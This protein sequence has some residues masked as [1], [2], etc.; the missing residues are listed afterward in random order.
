MAI[1]NDKKINKHYLFLIIMI[2]LFLVSI[3]LIIFDY[4]IS[5]LIPISMAENP[6]SVFFDEFGFGITFVPIYFMLLI[7]ILT[8]SSGLIKTKKNKRLIYII[9]QIVFILVNLLFYYYNDSF[10]YIKGNKYLLTKLLSSMISIIIFFSTYLGINIYIF[11][12]KLHKDLYWLTNISSKT[13]YAFFVIFFSQI[14]LQLIK[15]I[16]GRNRPDDVLF[17][18][19][20]FYYAFEPNFNK[21]R[22]SSFVSGHVLSAG[23]LFIFLFFLYIPNKKTKMIKIILIVVFSIISLLVGISRITMLKHFATDVYFSGVLLFVFFYYSK[24][25][26]HWFRKKMRPRNV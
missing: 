4:K 9:F 18:N 7:F 22:G 26:V 21:T 23:L 12:K 15:V 19:Q 8:I 2:T 20:T 1:K 10:A 5:Q 24:D 6:F 3:P 25:V 14:S 11:K 16:F 13:G 17:N